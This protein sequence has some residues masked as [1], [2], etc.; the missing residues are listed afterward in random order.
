M[1][2]AL[3]LLLVAAA[4]LARASG[5]S[6]PDATL[7]TSELSEFAAQPAPVQKLLTRALELTTRNLTYQYGSSDPSIGGM[8]C[9]GTIYW[10]L[11]DA[12]VKNVP[13]DASEMYKWVWMQSRLEAVSSFNADTFELARLHPGDLMFWTGTYDVQRDPPITHVM[14]YLGTRR[15]NG[16]RVMIGA[17]D[18]RTFEGKQRFGV[19]VFDFQMPGARAASGKGTS[20]FVGYGPVPGLVS[21]ASR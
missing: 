9:S 18:G 13:R 8:D 20:R 11:N 5:E 21:D 4:M 7:P 12:G 2:R 6:A 17:S 14:I 15:S 10:L 3:L 1:R 19:S 16:Q